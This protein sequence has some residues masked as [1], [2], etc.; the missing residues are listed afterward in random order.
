MTDI[1]KFTLGFS[2]CPN[3]TFMF[4]ALVNGK[5]D[6]NGIFFSPELE[7]IETL[8][9]KALS[10]EFDITKVSFGVFTSISNTYELLNSGAALGSGVGPLFISKKKFEDISEIKTVAIPG[11]HT[12]AYILFKIFYPQITTT[13]EMIFSEIE[14]A[15]LNGEVDAGVIIHENRFTYESKGLRKISDLGELWEKQTGQPI[16]LGGIVIR[17]NISPEIKK[18]VNDLL[19]QSIEFAFAHPE[20]GFDYIKNHAQ[21][22]SEEVRKKHIELY[23]NKYSIDLGENGKN[24]V[25]IFLE[26]V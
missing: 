18:N 20:S 17:K 13:K 15:I 24:A 26:H 3:D 4:D 2:P 10:G 1:K 19:R 25:R 8:N 14:Q 7:D 6:T 5:I 16:P 9:R 23:V 21:E 12:T 11:K 22:M